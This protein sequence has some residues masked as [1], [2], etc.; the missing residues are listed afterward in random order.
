MAFLRDYWGKE[1]RAN[2]L[3]H[4]IVV[5]NISWP[6]AAA[7]T[8]ARLSIDG[9]VVDSSTAPLTFKDIAVLSGSITEEGRIHVIEVY[10]K[11]R[12]KLKIKICAD[13]KFIGGDNF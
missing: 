8:E 12:L 5:R 10:A 2:F 7:T 13:G 11:M 6:A 9:Q 4:T 3:G 1:V